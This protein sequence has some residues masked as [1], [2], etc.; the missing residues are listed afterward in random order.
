MEKRSRA[1]PAKCRRQ[2]KKRTI[3]ERAKVGINPRPMLRFM[4]RILVEDSRAI[5]MRKGKYSP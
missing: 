2:A 4:G 5:R 1:S 3:A